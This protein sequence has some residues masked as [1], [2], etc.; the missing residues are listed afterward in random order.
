[1]RR[2][3]TVAVCGSA[4]IHSTGVEA[5]AEDLGAA[6]IRG[7]M[8]LVTGGMG[9]VMEAASRG[10]F[11]ARIAG[12]GEGVVIGVLPGDD[13]S[14]ANRYCNVVIPSGMGIGRNLIVVRSADAV[15]LVE[16]GSGTL[17]EASFAWQ[18]GKTVVALVTSNGWAER[19]GGQKLDERRQDQIYAVRTPGEAIALIQ[20]ELDF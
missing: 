14:E 8:S 13:L 4:T 5:M 2:L 20:D 18:L 16:G 9:G 19:L 10:A 17:S 12:E 1:M 7:G 3:P 11:Q 6:I 15:V